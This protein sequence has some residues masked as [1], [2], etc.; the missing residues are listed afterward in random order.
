M[1]RI[2]VLLADGN[3]IFGFFFPVQFT[4]KTRQRQQRLRTAWRRS[5][6]DVKRRSERRPGSRSPRG[7]RLTRKHSAELRGAFVCRFGSNGRPCAQHVCECLY[8]TS[9]GKCHARGWAGPGSGW[10][11]LQPLKVSRGYSASALC[12]ILRPSSPPGDDPTAFDAGCGE[13]RNERNGFLAELFQTEGLINA[14]VHSLLMRC[15]PVW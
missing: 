2:A 5:Q 10:V 13:S 7:N 15:R 8:I 9:S 14:T 11:V 1:E 4:F 6:S 3:S 12:H